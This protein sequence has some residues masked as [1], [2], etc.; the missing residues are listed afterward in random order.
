MFRFDARSRV[1]IVFLVGLLVVGPIRAAAPSERAQ[2]ATKATSA[3]ATT[4]VPARKP[5][6]FNHLNFGTVYVS[7]VNWGEQVDLVQ[8]SKVSHAHSTL[9]GNSLGMEWEHFFK[10]RYG[11]ALQGALMSGVID[12][13]GGRNAPLPYTLASQHWWGAEASP[14]L[15][16]RF[17]TWIITSSSVMSCR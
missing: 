7:L 11:F 3:G 13:G 15:A 10:E 6:K 5:R 9:L 4:A 8:G 2:T 17:S 16:Y 1:S 12:V 14:R